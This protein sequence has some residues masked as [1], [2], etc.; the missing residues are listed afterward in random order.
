MQLIKILAEEFSMFDQ[1]GG[2][3]GEEGMDE[4]GLEGG[5]EG[6]DALDAS[7]EGDDCQCQCTCPCCQKNAGKDDET[8][9]GGEEGTFDFSQSPASGDGTPS[10]DDEFEFKI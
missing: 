6:M 1:F 3:T 8:M 7:P 5:M 10:T 2:K 9:P 4:L